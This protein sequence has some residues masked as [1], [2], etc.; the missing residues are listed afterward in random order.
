VDTTMQVWMGLT[1]GCAKC[2]SHKFD[3]ITQEEYYRFYAIYNQTTDT[4]QPDERPTVPVPNPE[5][6][7]KIR[8]IDGRIAAIKAKIGKSTPAPEAEKRKKEIAALEKSR[9]KALEV[10]V[11]AE[12]PLDKRRT[13]RL[14]RKGNFL[15]PG[16]PVQPGVPAALHPLPPGA[17]VNR[18]TLARWLVDPKNPLTE[19]VAVNRFWAQLF[20]VG[21]VDTEED[22]GTQGEP[23]S[24]PEL[25][26]WPAL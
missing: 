12:L 21:L 4:D 16:D 19:R 26:D 9:P 11:M 22:F 20:G 13:T 24:H 25:L 14:L 3:P 6:S 10:P 18:L 15:D 5:I 1:I 23:P 8:E 17:P 2:H 7:A